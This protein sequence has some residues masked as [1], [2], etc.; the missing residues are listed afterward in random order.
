MIN[1]IKKLIPSSFKILIKN[2]INVIKYR[3]NKYQCPLCNYGCKQFLPIGL[4]YEVIKEKKIIGAGRR[5]AACPKC[6]SIDRERLIFLYFNKILCKDINLSN[7]KLLHIAPE[8]RLMDYFINL[9]IEEYVCGDLFAEG[10]NYPR[11]VKKLDVTNLPFKNDH[12][13]LIICNHVLEHINDDTKAI[14]EIYRVLKNNGKAILQVPISFKIDKTYEDSRV[15]SPKQRE[16]KFG[17]ND[18][19]RVYGKDYVNRLESCGFR[20]EVSKLSAEWEYY[21]TNTK[22][23]IFVAVKS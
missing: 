21:G 22:E 5:N 12:F 10:Y 18:H 17:Q 11:L 15:T 7:S 6:Y 2:K 9:N 1:K 19:V 4:D 23:P 20:V 13:D 8:K 3:G 14:K 16:I